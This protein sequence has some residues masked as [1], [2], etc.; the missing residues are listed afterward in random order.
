MRRELEILHVRLF[1]AKKRPLRLMAVLITG[2]TG[3][4]KSHLARQYVWTH[5]NDYPGG[6][7]WV[8]AKTFQS[9]CT[10]FWDIAV[11]VGL[12]DGKTELGGSESKASA[13]HVD[14]VRHWFQAREEWLLIFDGL[15]FDKDEDISRLKQFLPNNKNCAIIYTS[16]D[17]TL[18]RKQRLFEPY[19]LTVPPLREEDGCKLL[20]KDMSIKRPTPQQL[21]KA[22]EL[23]RHFEGLPLAIHAISHRLS[24]ASKPIEKYRV[25]SHLTDQKL[26]E[27][28]LG[29]MNDLYRMRRFEALYLINLLSY[30]GHRIPV[31]LIV[32]GR[33]ALE[34]WDVQILTS[35]RPGERPDLDTTLQTLIKYGLIERTTHPY[36]FWHPKHSP[37]QSSESVDLKR[38]VIAA[39]SSESP[40]ESSSQDGFFAAYQNVSVIDIIKIHSVVQ[41][42]CRD[43]LKIMDE[44]T[45]AMGTRDRST[46][47]FYDSWLVVATRVFC[48]AYEKAKS[49]MDMQ[50]VGLSKDYREFST[51]GCVL[52][53]LYPKKLTSKSPQLV[54][55]ARSDLENTMS[56]IE[57]QI[58]AIP[59]HT[60]QEEIRNNRS[61]F[62]RYS[63][64]SSSIPDSDEGPSRQTTWDSRVFEP[65]A[66]EALNKD[67]P[68]PPKSVNLGPF[69]PH[70]YRYTA[71]EAGYETDTEG[72]NAT[73]RSSPAISQISEDTERP[74]SSQASTPTNLV[75]DFEWNVVN[76]SRFVRPESK[77]KPILPILTKS[78]AHRIPEPPGSHS[79]AQR[80]LETL[81][82]GRAR[83]EEPPT[84]SLKENSR[85]YANVAVEHSEGMTIPG[86]ELS[87]SK[88]SFASRLQGQPSY[89]SLYSDG[90]YTQRQSW[91]RPTDKG[92]LDRCRRPAQNEQSH[93]EAR[94][95]RKLKALD[96]NSAPVSRY[97]SRH[98]TA[99]IP[100]DLSASS[101]S[102]SPSS[103]V[104]QIVG[105]LGTGDEGGVGNQ[106]VSTSKP[107]SN[108]SPLAHP[109]AIMPGTSPPSIITDLPSG[110]LTEPVQQE[111]VS[112]AETMPGEKPQH[113][114]PA[115]SIVS[116]T[117]SWMD[118]VSAIFRK[119]GR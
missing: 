109:S 21:Q 10:C 90:S 55:E 53:E 67:R 46:A 22:K 88:N 20:F 60:S 12:I 117:G 3:S 54:Y 33:H 107:G 77:T 8:D 106:R 5:L 61:V 38:V 97:H 47:G 16:I 13:K 57:R 62:D 27:P 11:E 73:V 79:P 112:H 64:P 100:A 52:L 50:D 42:F 111:S 80:A 17:K 81:Q 114:Q 7:F 113:S 28:F 15:C 96:L 83:L 35:S 30:L 69:P 74:R 84:L 78:S 102:I 29:I 9:T 56:S 66:A 68:R 23:V 36:D 93:L 59:P 48:K 2:V 44:E 94:I 71:G 6:I 119:H 108:L 70:I 103:H 87:L 19:C 4:G 39:D 105:N 72:F 85:N 43:E 115:D 118:G 1:K 49:K 101:P 92:A 89:E 18:A 99:A 34:D 32:L 26:A 24:A 75:D 76:A 58:D 31:G 86:K 104:G 45:K 51:H 25:N 95:T 63:S 40:T 37:Q 14:A 41:R 98:S 91:I 65:L 82:R 110:Y 116:G